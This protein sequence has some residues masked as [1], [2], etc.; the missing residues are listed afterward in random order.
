MELCYVRDR[1]QREVDFVVLRDRKPWLLVEAKESE[2]T[3]SPALRYFRERLGARY[4]VQVIRSGEG[5]R[6]VVPAE[7]WLAALP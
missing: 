5:R 1:E 3:Q 6:D 7:R 4:A 2:G